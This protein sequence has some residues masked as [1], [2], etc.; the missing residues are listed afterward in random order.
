MEKIK[1]GNIC[2][3]LSA[4]HC[5]NH[6]RAG[7]VK[8]KEINTDELIKKIKEKIDIS[9][10]YKTESENEDA[11]W[12][13]D[14]IYKQKAEIFVRENGVKLLLDIHGMDLSRKEDICIGTAHGRN[15]KGREDILKLLENTFKINGYKNTTIDE[16]FSASNPNCVSTYISRNCNIPAFQIEINNKYRYPLSKEYNLEKLVDTFVNIIK[17]LKI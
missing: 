16:P 7:K 12:D 4:P 5:V 10:I 2:V 3:M 6:L 1:K 8:P 17:L 13:K 11:N 15:I 9:I 14:S